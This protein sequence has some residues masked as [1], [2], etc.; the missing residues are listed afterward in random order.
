MDTPHACEEWVTSAKSSCASRQILCN[1]HNEQNV[2]GDVA[3]RFW[4]QLCHTFDPAQDPIEHMRTVLRRFPEGALAGPEV[5]LGVQFLTHFA[6]LARLAD[7]PALR[8]AGISAKKLIDTPN[9]V[10]NIRELVLGNGAVEVNCYYHLN[11]TCFLY[12]L[13]GM[14]HET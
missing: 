4:D 3:A 10:D 14:F 8:R 11:T 5:D 7:Q 13:P 1:L 12:G 9:L 6:V 2:P